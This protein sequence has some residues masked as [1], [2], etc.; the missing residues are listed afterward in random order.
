MKLTTDTQAKSKQCIIKFTLARGHLYKEAACVTFSAQSLFQVGLQLALGHL[1]AK[2]VL[3]GRP[4][5]IRSACFLCVLYWNCYIQGLGL[6]PKVYMGA[7][8]SLHFRYDVKHTTDRIANQKLRLAM[9]KG[10]LQSCHAVKACPLQT[11]QL[12]DMPCT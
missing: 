8:I 7:A 9:P 10:G 12:R 6:H 1:P 11:P 4:A 3:E 5:F 2:N